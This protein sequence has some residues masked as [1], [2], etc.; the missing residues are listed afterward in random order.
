MPCQQSKHEHYLHVYTLA[1]DEWWLVQVPDGPK[2]FPTPHMFR[3]WIGI[4]RQKS[5]NIPLMVQKSGDHHLLY[6]KSHEKIGYS[7]CQLL[8]WISEPSTVFN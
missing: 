4:T 2:N 8:S 1:S 5:W 7:Q 3:L 6:I